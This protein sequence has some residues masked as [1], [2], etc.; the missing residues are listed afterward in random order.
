MKNYF[1]KFRETF[2]N[3]PELLNKLGTSQQDQSN[4]FNGHI[5]RFHLSFDMLKNITPD[6]VC[7]VGTLLPYVS[8]YF[9]LSGS[10]LNCLCPMKNEKAVMSKFNLFFRDF[11]ICFDTVP[12]ADLILCTECLEHL[13]VNIFEMV[14][15]LCSAVNP[16]GYL[17]LSFPCGGVNAKDYDKTLGDPLQ[18]YSKHIREFNAN[19]SQMFVDYIKGKGFELIETRGTLTSLYRAEIKHH[20]FKRGAA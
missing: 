19:T 4:Y 14:D 12:K 18:V 5:E 16:E 8:F 3:N 11:N 1:E 2:I 7:D 20:L 6:K 9:A 17:F 15:K 13:P 10:E